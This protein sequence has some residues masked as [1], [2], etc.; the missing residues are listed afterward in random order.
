MSV[1]CW[2]LTALDCAEVQK[3]R[4]HLRPEGT[5]RGKVATGNEVENCETFQP[6]QGRQELAAQSAV[7]VE[8]RLDYLKEHCSYSN[9][10][11]DR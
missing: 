11:G 6:N 10:T 3:R 7:G 8:N 5:G 1:G 2:R 4:P 9:L